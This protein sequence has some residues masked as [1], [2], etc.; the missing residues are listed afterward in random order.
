MRSVVRAVRN[1]A[2]SAEDVPG[3]PPSTPSGLA[4]LV[5]P[6]AGTKNIVRG[7]MISPVIPIGTAV[8]V[9]LGGKNLPVWS[10]K[11]P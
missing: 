8:S 2:L 9:G 3:L 4:R 6:P 7:A 10:A 5:S 11:G 1:S